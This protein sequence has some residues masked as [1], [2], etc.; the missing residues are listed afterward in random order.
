[1]TQA[2]SSAGMG[3]AYAAAG[4][5]R[6]KRKRRRRRSWTAHPQHDGD[7][8]QVAHFF[9][10]V[11]I[12]DLVLEAG[13]QLAAVGGVSLAALGGQNGA[14]LERN[15]VGRRQDRAVEEDV[16][17]ADGEPV[18]LADVFG[19]GVGVAVKEALGANVLET[20]LKLAA[21]S[22]DGIERAQMRLDGG[23]QGRVGG[24][25]GRGILKQ[26]LSALRVEAGGPRLRRLG[27]C[28]SRG[29]GCGGV[30]WKGMEW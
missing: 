24:G 9:V 4:W 13:A 1:M 25:V 3:V 15:L 29:H 17:D 20:L 16:L 28:C 26:V 12:V 7:G 11:A 23:G 6:W 21:G 10:P 27:L 14:I 18:A 22:E 8:A 5:R 30:V 2:V 19:L